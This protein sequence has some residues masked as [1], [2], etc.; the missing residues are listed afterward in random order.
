MIGDYLDI[1]TY[2]YLLDLAL[3]RVP[4]N[5]DKR[6]G[7]I[8]YD[9]LAP[10]CYELAEFY[11]RQKQILTDTYATTSSGQYLDLRVA[12]QGISRYAATYAKRRGIFVDNEG[13]PAYIALGARFSTI[14]SSNTVNFYVESVYEE[15]GEVV[16]GSYILV[17]EDLGTIGNGYIGPIIPISNISN[18]A[19]ATL[20]T[21]LVPARDEETDEEL[22]ER[23]FQRVNES[24][25]GGNVTQYIQEIK[26]I[27]GV[28]AV[29]VYPVW[30]GGGTVKCSVID[31]NYSAISSEFVSAIQE[32]IDPTQDGS[33]LG[34]AP[35]GHIVTITTPTALPIRI[36]AKITVASGY[37]LT[38]LQES[39]ENAIDK[40]LLD[41]RQNWANG[42]ELNQYSSSVY[43]ARI[44]AAILGVVGVSNVT[45][46]TINNSAT[47]LLL[48][49]D[50]NVQQLPVL[51]E[52]KLSE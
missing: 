2:K 5:L 10:A 24:A 26:D 43:V 8:I 6:E 46:V 18:L 35:I 52:V 19:T 22:R 41:I 49:Q 36:G 14:D 51:G 33:G 45:N 13:K 27:E 3:S 48:L 15:E 28:G 9:A 39:I 47:D 37:N 38:Q 17:C 7:S 40:Y 20:G 21:V 29:Q 23:Y 44:T 12:E 42:D 50:A 4:D 30:N 34:T 11:M 31:A 1:Y 16:P 32:E 25:F